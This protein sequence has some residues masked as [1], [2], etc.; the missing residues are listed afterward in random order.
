MMHGQKT[1]KLHSYVTAE[2][3]KLTLGYVILNKVN[4]YFC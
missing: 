1:I 3:N 4:F 2:K